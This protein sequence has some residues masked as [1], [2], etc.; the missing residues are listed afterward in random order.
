MFVATTDRLRRELYEEPP[1]A[2]MKT[3]IRWTLSDPVYQD[4]FLRVLGR[5]LPATAMSSR[6]MMAGAIARG[7]LR[8]VTGALAR[9]GR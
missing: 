4:T 7:A 3:M 9:L 1:L 5:E 6:S 2:V 8:D